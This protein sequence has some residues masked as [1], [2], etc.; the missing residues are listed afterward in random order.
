MIQIG[1]FGLFRP[2]HLEVRARVIE[3]GAERLTPRQAVVLE[4]AGDA[5]LCRAGTRVIRSNVVWAKGGVVE[6]AIPGKIQR[7]YRGVAAVRAVANELVP[8]VTMELE[9][10]VAAAVAAEAPKAPPE[11]MKA[12]AA[13]TRSYY[14]A[15]QGRHPLFDFCDT[16]HCQFLTEPAAASVAAARAT[17]GQLLL[18]HGHHFGPMFFRSC[19][20]QTLTA[21][22]VKLNFT[23]YPY[24]AVACTGCASNPRAW[25]Y[26]IRR[27]EAV[28]L[29]EGGPSENAR[30]EIARRHGWGSLASNHYRVELDG[31]WAVFH[32]K[33]EGHG[34][35]LCQR[36]AAAMAVAGHGHRA[37]LSHYF[38]ET[39]LAGS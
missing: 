30:L 9:D 10:A 26:R 34:L 37:I 2:K 15:H 13:V 8:A 6:M 28:N 31:E 3:A 23:P 11:A 39:E 4:A 20:G 27:E 35:G 33:G 24:F 21:A 7:R 18:H 25:T 22:A 36:G 38:P 5:V 32:G 29:I 14:Q 17:A 12:Q 16:T 19:G 1:I